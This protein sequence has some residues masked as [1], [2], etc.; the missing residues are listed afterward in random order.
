MLKE[1]WE[2]FLREGEQSKFTKVHE[3]IIINLSILLI[4]II[5]VM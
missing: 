5:F 2:K 1:N 3:E 4:L